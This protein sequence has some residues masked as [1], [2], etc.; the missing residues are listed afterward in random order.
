MGLDQAP[1]DPGPA[2]WTNRGVKSGGSPSD[3]ALANQGQAK[4]FAVKAEEELRFWLPTPYNGPI[5]ATLPPENSYQP[6]NQGQLKN[7]VKPLYDRIHA[8]ALAY[9]NN[10]ILDC[11]PQGM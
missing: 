4:W 6:I 10:H 1:A 7:L 3:Y 2:W 11:L 9:P 8:A 5:L